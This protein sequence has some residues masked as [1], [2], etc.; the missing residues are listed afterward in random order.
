MGWNEL[1][2]WNKKKTDRFR[3][4]HGFENIKDYMEKKQ[5]NHGFGMNCVFGRRRKMMGLDELWI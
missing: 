4:N 1:C 3:T 2:T 5:K